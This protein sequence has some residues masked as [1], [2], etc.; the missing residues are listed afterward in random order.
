MT[1]SL[2]RAESPTDMFTSGYM[3]MLMHIPFTQAPEQTC[4]R[5]ARQPSQC[6][7]YSPTYC[8]GPSMA[9]ITWARHAAV[10]Q[11]DCHA[12]DAVLLWTCR[13]YYGKRG[14]TTPPMRSPALKRPRPRPAATP[15]KVSCCCRYQESVMSS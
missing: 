13:S 11:S 9:W 8:M 6:G 14:W 3:R 5:P 15:P 12:F 10:V 1:N 4:I 7:A 2:H